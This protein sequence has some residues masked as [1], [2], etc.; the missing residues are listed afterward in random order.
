MTDLAKV[1]QTGPTM[2][3]LEIANLIEKR[4]DSVKLSIER[5][6]YAHIIVQPPLVDEPGTDA[7]GRYR[8]TSVYLLSKRGVNPFDKTMPYMMIA[9]H[10]LLRLKKPVDCGTL[11]TALMT[12]FNWSKPMAEERA[13]MAFVALLHVG[14]ITTVEG[15]FAIKGRVYD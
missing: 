12:K 8:A 1:E 5:L 13:R 7:Q 14:A 6:V 3:S 9:A 4:H 11:T 2:S 10:L 15:S